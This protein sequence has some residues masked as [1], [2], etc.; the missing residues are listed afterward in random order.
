MFFVTLVIV[1][2]ACAQ[3][4]FSQTVIYVGSNK[5]FGVCWG[6]GNMVNNDQCAR[7]HCVQ[8]G[9]INPQR[10]FSTPNK[11]FGALVRAT[12][13]AMGWAAGYAT[14]TDAINAAINQC[15]M[16]GGDSNFTAEMEWD[17]RN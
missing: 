4:A 9:G 10:V 2:T 3:S 14:P 11:G 16:R 7:N 12:N 6:G 5:A 17:D 15:R 8:R 13:G 1:L